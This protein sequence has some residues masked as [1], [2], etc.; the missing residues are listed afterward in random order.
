LPRTLTGDTKLLEFQ[1]KIIHR[2][3]AAD[4]VVSYFDSTVSELCSWCNTRNN[5]VHKFVYCAKV[6]NFWIEFDTFLN[7]LLPTHV[8]VTTEHIILGIPNAVSFKINFLIL[9]AKWFIHDFCKDNKN[10]IVPFHQFIVY[11]KYIIAVE[12]ERVLMKEDYN[13]ILNNLRDIHSLCT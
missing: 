4:S 8:N 2:C 9:H 10:R 13:N 5:I 12:R 7:K 1:F 3:Y 6:F 11:I